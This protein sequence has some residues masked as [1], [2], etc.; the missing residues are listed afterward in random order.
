MADL[1]ALARERVLLLDGAMGTAIQDLRL[2]AEAFGA[3]AGCLEALVLTAPERV[4]GIHRAYLEAGADL[5]ETDTFGASPQVL[6]EFGLAGRCEELNEAAARL[7]RVEAARL[8]SPGRPRFVAGSV[9]PGTRLPSLGQGS[10]AELRAGF[11]RQIEGLL[12][13]GVDLL[14]IET[15]QDLLQARAALGAARDAMAAS[16]RV[17]LWVSVT[18]EPGGSLLTGSDLGAVVAVLEPLGVDVL[19]LNCGT[20]PVPMRPHLEALARTWPGL[21]GVYPNAGLPRACAGG[22]RY[23]EGPEELAAALASFLD[24][25]PLS[26]VGGCCG[27][28]P[29]HIRRLAE[30]LGGR[31]PRP[32]PAPEPRPQLAS[33]FSAVPIAQQPPP[34]YIGERANATGSRAFRDALLGG[35]HRAAFELLDAQAEQ[36]SHAA[37]LSVAFAGQDEPRH[38][39]ALVELAAR[40]CRLPL[41]IDSNSVDAIQLALELYPGRA[42]VN[43]VNLE[44]GGA[45]ADRLGPLAREHGAALICGCIDEQ[46]MAMTARRKLEVAE[47]LVERCVGRY[48]LRPGDLLVDPLTFTVGSGDASLRAAAQETLEGLRLIRARLPGVHTLLGISNV[49]FG[50]SA[51]SRP[52]LNSVFLE[53]AL[54]AGLT[55]A[56]LD[57]RHILPLPSLPPEEVRL[58]EA[59]L[60]DRRDGGREPLQAFVEHFAGRPAAPAAAEAAELGPREA[61]FQGVLHGR[62]SQVLARLPAL[63]GELPAGAVLDE[64]LLPAM[65]RVGELF[66]AGELQLPFVLKSAEAMKLAVDA[67]RPRLGAGR[68]SA[69]RPRRLLLATVRGDVHD[70]GKNLVDIILSNNGVEV[71]DLGI[72]VPVET[73]VRQ[74]RE[75]AVD[76]VGM[77]GLLVSSALVMAENLRA[78]SDQGLRLPV[79]VGGAALTPGFV[80]DVLAPA[81]PGGEVI[82]C[83]DAFDGLRAMQRLDAGG[84][85]PAPGPAVGAG[86]LPRDAY[87]PGPLALQEVT[88][89]RPPFLGSRV[90]ED[91]RLQDVLAYLNP[92]A[93]VRGRW[94]YRRGGLTRAEYE[95]VLEREVRPRQAALLELV[96]R[97]ELFRPRLVYGFFE[98]RGQGERVRIADGGREHVLEFPRRRREPRLCLA[99]FVRPDGDVLGLFAVSLGD[100]AVRRGRQVLARDGYLDYFLLHGLAVEA[101]E[102]LAELAHARLRQELGIGEPRP[103]GWQ[104]LVTQRYRGSRYGFGYP[105][106]PDLSA[107]RLVFELLRPERI[108][109][110]LAEGFQLVPEYATVA[111]VLHHPQAKYFAT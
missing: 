94:G 96:A 78:M 53:A 102:A 68:R 34:L 22:V 99:D 27:T 76:A 8:S 36:G 31:A 6:G 82:Y 95:Q 55:A 25:L 45:R 103:L 104:E 48:G 105:A 41:V 30:L 50:L 106:A 74:A 33:L 63:L 32:R 40:G 44:D 4:A 38:M 15:V 71:L 88:P 92:V 73:I 84:P 42:A 11:R 87:P 66:G 61:V 86:E 91:I 59:L 47:R 39:R 72:K 24:S 10:Y 1:L 60:L 7:A 19:G 101:T 26:F 77:S 54:R 23:P 56:I 93:L 52:V 111:L 12:A 37:D 16:R 14:L 97:E 79:L 70:I 21:L 17:P 80:R 13:G 67:L 89:P 46:G 51:R 109:L 18:V 57:P 110:A 62:G 108:G 85:P 5:V 20:G 29:A 2:P 35:D 65:R 83:A 107:H 3:H 75:H 98:A 100:E 64:V 58:A 69:D 81:Y 90:V 43:S 9:G 49:S 28:T